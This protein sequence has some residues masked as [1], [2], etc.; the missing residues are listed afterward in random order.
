MTQKLQQMK[1]KLGLVAFYII[2][3]VN[4]HTYHTYRPH[5]ATKQVTGVN[6]YQSINTR[7]V[8]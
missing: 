7:E 8:K 3:P 6:Q 4:Y 5:G 2:W 1:L